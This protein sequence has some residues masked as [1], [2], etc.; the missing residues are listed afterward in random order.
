MSSSSST[1]SCIRVGYRRLSAAARPPRATAE[2]SA[3]YVVYAAYTTVLPPEH[4]TLVPTDLAFVARADFLALVFPVAAN[5]FNHHL[6]LGTHMLSGAYRGNAHFLLRNT[7]RYNT[8]RIMPGAPLAY[9]R[10][11][12]GTPTVIGEISGEMFAACTRRMPPRLLGRYPGGTRGPSFFMEGDR[13]FEPTPGRRSVSPNDISSTASSSMADHNSSNVSTEANTSGGDNGGGDDDDDERPLVIVE[14]EAEDGGEP[15][16]RQEIV[17]V[18]V[19]DEGERGEPLDLSLSSRW[20][21][22]RL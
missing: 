21:R 11:I 8:V 10:W 18:Q 1:V 17:L 6:Q 5:Q 22:V 20:R 14:E 7:S 13:W 15:Q 2:G 12:G 3:L 4:S 19:D 9:L 16:E